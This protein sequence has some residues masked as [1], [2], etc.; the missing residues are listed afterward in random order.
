MGE[1]W[2]LRGEKEEKKKSGKVKSL[3]F[4]RLLHFGLRRVRMIQYQV[5]HQ[6]DKDKK[7]ISKSGLLERVTKMLL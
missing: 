6:T 1:N 4:G 3:D 5:S 2:A 7:K